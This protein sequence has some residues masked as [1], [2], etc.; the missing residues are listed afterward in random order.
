MSDKDSDQKNDGAKKDEE[1]SLLDRSTAEL[2]EYAE[3]STREPTPV[4]GKTARAEDAD[5][6]QVPERD[7]SEPPD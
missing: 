7:G 3:S 4:V 6:E 2:D 1:P 5:E